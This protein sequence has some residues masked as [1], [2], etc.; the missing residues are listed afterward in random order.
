[1]LIAVLG[2]GTTGA[3]IADTAVVSEVDVR[4]SGS[5]VWPPAT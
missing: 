3:G 1:M 5:A 2:A 4:A